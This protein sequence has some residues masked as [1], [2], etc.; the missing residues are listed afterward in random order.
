MEIGSILPLCSNTKIINYKNSQLTI[1]FLII[2]LEPLVA[3]PQ[4]FYRPW[5]NNYCKDKLVI[6]QAIS[7]ETR[8]VTCTCTY[9]SSYMT[10]LALYLPYVQGLFTVTNVIW[11][12]CLNTTQI[13]NMQH[14]IYMNIVYCTDAWVIHSGKFIAGTLI[15][16]I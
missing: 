13:C 16:I 4:K 6:L 3:L 7:M 2:S 1:T 10:K 15:I 5:H 9:N 11:N 12:L 14:D 8:V